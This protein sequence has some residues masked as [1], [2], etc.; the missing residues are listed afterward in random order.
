MSEPELVSR[1]FRDVGRLVRGLSSLPELRR[2]LRRRD[3][4]FSGARDFRSEP[5]VKGRCSSWLEPDAAQPLTAAAYVGGEGPFLD[6]FPPLDPRSK[7]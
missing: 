4:P 2:G 7:E 6:F 3:A 5:E 1:R